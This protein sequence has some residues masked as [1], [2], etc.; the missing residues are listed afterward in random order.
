MNP[1]GSCCT[2]TKET[3]K[4][5]NADKNSHILLVFKHNSQ[6]ILT[7]FPLCNFPGHIA[8]IGTFILIF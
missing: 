2:L 6:V 5:D 3:G 1:L 4:N 7:C 8:V